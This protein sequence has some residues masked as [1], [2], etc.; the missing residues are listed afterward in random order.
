MKTIVAATDFSASAHDALERAAQLA[1]AHG[2]QLHLL[3]AP[4]HGTW[5]QGTGMF[6]HLFDDGNAP[7]V[8]QDRARL[9]KI[10]AGLKRRFRVKAECHVLPGKAAVEIAAFAQSR[11][12]DL[13][14]V[15]SRGEGGVKRL[16]L[17]STALKVTWS[18]L[19]PVLIVREPVEAGYA[20]M[21]VATDLSQR[22][23][24]VC[25][26]AMALL[27]RASIT[28]VHAFRAEFETAL[29]L[30][31]ARAEALRRYR[32]EE[33]TEAASQLEKLWAEVRG[34]SRR[35][36]ERVISHGHPIP[37][38]LKAVAEYAPELVVLGKH[39]GP[40]WEEQ[41]LGSVVQNLLQQLKT[42]VLVVP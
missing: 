17:G 14:V 28:L 6:S 41:V 13:V 19:C 1:R 4:S 27:P 7:S 22:S 3:H 36:A 18:T 25:T 23:A 24:H 16:A 2:A 12:A 30:V 9:E 37:V 21:L 15:A 38:V 31:G 40:R 8:E 29:E 42:D 34:K 32:A 35:Q 39:A 33:G 5:S 11:E 10:G 26:S 20:S